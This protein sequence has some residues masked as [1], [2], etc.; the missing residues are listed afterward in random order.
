VSFDTTHWSLVSAIRSE[1]PVVKQR[2]L[3]KN[4][5]W[6]ALM[7]P[8]VERTLPSLTWVDIGIALRDNRNAT[9]H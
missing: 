7:K 1:D 4:C 5:S 6:L 8:Y 9:V 3:D 2:A